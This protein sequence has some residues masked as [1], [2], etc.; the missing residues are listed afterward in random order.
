MVMVNFRSI[1]VF[2][3]FYIYSLVLVG[4]NYVFFFDILVIVV[5]VIIFLDFFKVI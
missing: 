2:F 1:L 4:N 5:E 3:I